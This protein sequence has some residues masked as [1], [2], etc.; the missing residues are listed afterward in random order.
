MTAKVIDVLTDEETAEY[1][2]KA[3]GLKSKYNAAAVHP[4]VMINPDTKER[5]VA[6]LREPSYLQK[7]F[8]MDKIAQV[9]PFV[10]GD[11]LRSALTIQEESDLLTYGESS[12]CD[13]YKLG[14]TTYC[15]TLINGLAECL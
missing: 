3:D 8:A 1:Q 13:P 12:E 6:Y 9:G 2:A 10:A 11:E 15:V 4:I 5:V 7:I 14:C